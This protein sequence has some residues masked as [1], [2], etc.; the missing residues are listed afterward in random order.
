MFGNNI[1]A[2]SHNPEQEDRDD[3]G[4]D[5]VAALF[6]HRL[7]RRDEFHGGGPGWNW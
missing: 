7:D 2:V 5:D 4:G 1:G 3:P 6:A